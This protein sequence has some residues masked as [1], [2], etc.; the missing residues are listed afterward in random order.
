[1]SRSAAPDEARSQLTGVARGGALNLAGAV[2]GAL[3][4]FGLV[5]VVARS[6]DADSAGVL[7][8]STALFLVVVGL[9]VFGADTALNHFVLRFEELGR[10]AD[11]APLIRIARRPVM[12]S[13]SAVALV[14]LVAADP[15]ADALGL[16]HPRAGAALRVL[17]LAVPFAAW[18]Q[19]TLALT[20]ALGR[21]RPT[22]VVDSILRSAAQVVAVAVVGVLGG[23]LTWL[24]VAWAG[25]YVLAALLAA[26]IATRY[27][28]RRS[29]RWESG[30]SSDLPRLR[31]EYHRYAVPRG[32]ARMSQIV[33]QRADVVIIAAVR[34]PA[35]AAVYTAATRFVVV[36]QMAAQAISNVLMPR[37]A[38]LL[39]RR[40]LTTVGAVF[41]V[42]TAWSIAVTWPVY[43]AT[44]GLATGYLRIFGDG[45]GGAEGIAVVVI[46][47]IAMMFATA[48][49]AL[50]TVLL[51]SGRSVASL[52]N[53]GVSAVLNV[54]LCLALIPV[55][56]IRGA[57]VA[58]ASAVVVRNLLSYVQ[59]RRDLGITPVSR[60]GATVAT[61]SLICFAGPTALLSLTGTASPAAVVG[62][63]A[64]GSAAY[65]AV[66][67]RSRSAL[68]LAV[69][70]SM[71][72]RRR[73]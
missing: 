8:S 16:D 63:L 7:F 54:G 11:I 32:V 59:V 30:G 48:A 29:R 23:G 12:W 34:G 46:M 22:V 61:A 31:A 53:A 3:A 37:L 56:G 55:V 47:S 1:M 70:R 9:A 19:L 50:D 24:T 39:S 21:M 44:A 14:V 49:G 45:Y 42:S 62:A 10:S 72:P 6:F 43:A 27:V 2:V 15:I 51:M 35:E 13:S 38:Q 71:L 36:G 40:D 20:R 52:V 64:A 68:E 4:G 66:V 5:A 57:A 25:P 67:W 60:V 17:A 73:S 69:F 28:R 65:A 26:P 41:K 58:W 33:I 18:A